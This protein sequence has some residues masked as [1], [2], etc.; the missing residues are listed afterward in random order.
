MEGTLSKETYKFLITEFKN[1]I[2]NIIDILIK[3][4]IKADVF[5]SYVACISDY[6]KGDTLILKAFID[7]SAE[8]LS[9]FKHNYRSKEGKKKDKSGINQ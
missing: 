9:L 2:D 5:L 8:Y 4:E 6:R 1:N 3:F 7:P